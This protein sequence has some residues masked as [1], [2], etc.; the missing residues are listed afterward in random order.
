MHPDVEKEALLQQEDVHSIPSSSSSSKRRSTSLLLVFLTISLSL[1]FTLLQFFNI[2]PSFPELFTKSASISFQPHQYLSTS[3][4]NPSPSHHITKRFNFSAPVKS[5]YGWLPEPERHRHPFFE[6]ISTPFKFNNSSPLIF[7]RATSATWVYFR[8]SE[9]EEGDVDPWKGEIPK[10]DEFLVVVKVRWP[11]IKDWEMKEWG[12]K[13]ISRFTGGEAIQ[14]EKEGQREAVGVYLDVPTQASPPAK[15]GR[16]PP[17]PDMTYFLMN[18][19]ITV[20][21]PPGFEGRDIEITR[22]PNRDPVSRMYAPASF[23]PGSGSFENVNVEAEVGSVGSSYGASSFVAKSLS[24][25]ISTE[26]EEHPSFGFVSGNF[27]VSSLNVTLGDVGTS[28]IQLNP[29]P[30]LPSS[31]SSSANATVSI[32]RYSK[33]MS[34]WNTIDLALPKGSFEGEFDV[35]TGFGDMDVNVV[36]EE[37]QVLKIE[38][39]G[40]WDGGSKNGIGFELLGSIRKKEGTGEGEGKIEM[41]SKEG[42]VNLKIA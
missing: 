28:S 29:H 11:L 19:Y 16:P 18:T 5:Y 22:I 23:G 8:S 42:V 32:G 10:K 17:N 31:S 20:V 15:P 1:L 13:E 35:R 2:C 37:G 3:L 12:M 26:E 34:G 38:R 4:L 39:V 40:E 41:L 36:P 6:S 9:N 33:Y 7:F 25:S 21:F 30:T 14:T 24:I 27:S